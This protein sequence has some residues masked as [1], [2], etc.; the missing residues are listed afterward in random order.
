MKP[1][2]E[3][4]DSIAKK[5][6]AFNQLNGF[7]PQQRQFLSDGFDLMNHMGR[8]AIDY[9]NKGREETEKDSF[10]QDPLFRNHNI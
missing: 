10:Q 6:D 3:Y 1:N 2:Q 4:L 7:E 9:M 8:A 5:L